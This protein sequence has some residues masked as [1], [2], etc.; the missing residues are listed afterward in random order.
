MNGLIR[1]ALINY[2]FFLIFMIFRDKS[3]GVLRLY[4]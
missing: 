4:E 3:K 2:D 1:Y